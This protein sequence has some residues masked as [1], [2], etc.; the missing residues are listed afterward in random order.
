ML[1]LGGQKDITKFV[2]NKLYKSNFLIIF[3]RL[4]IIILLYEYEG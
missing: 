2:I 4:A 1:D 3:V